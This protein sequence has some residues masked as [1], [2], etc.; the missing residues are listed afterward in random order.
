M[1]SLFMFT[2]TFCT[3]LSSLFSGEGT[4][5][6]IEIFQGKEIE[7]HTNEVV[8][9]CHMIYQEAPYYY[10]GDDAE[11]E[12]YLKSYSEA[13]HAIT[14]LVFDHNKPIGL[15]IGLPLANTRDPYKVPLLESG[16]TLK[17][18]FYIGEFG[19]SPEYLHQ[20]IEEQMYQ[21]I[22]SFSQQQGFTRLC[23]WE[24][25]N[26]KLNIEESFWKKVGFTLHPELNFS[27]SWT[28]IG[29]TDST[30]HIA[31]YWLKE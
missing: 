22:E 8:E 1:R 21:K 3:Y 11:Y 26:A 19:L 10:N 18:L 28:N 25:T 23:V 9:L 17:D 14:C 27:L 5:I 29:D 20:G 30:P 31:L 13:P 4:D 24:I 12:E 16:Y 7:S 2:L 6:R 15:A